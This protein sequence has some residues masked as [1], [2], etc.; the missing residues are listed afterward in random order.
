MVAP[1]NDNFADA[2]VVTL[3]NDQFVSTLTDTTDATLE[4]FEDGSDPAFD[5]SG[6]NSTWWRYDPASDQYLTLTPKTATGG[7]VYYD[8][9]LGPESAN[10]TRLT[11]NQLAD[12]GFT[13]IAL[14]QGQT[15]WVRVTVSLMAPSVTFDF[16]L[17]VTYPDLLGDTLAE[18]IDLL[19]VEGSMDLSLAGTSLEVSATNL[20]TNGDFE[21]DTST[22][23]VRTATLARSTVWANTG[24]AS[25]G[26]TPNS[27]SSTD[28]HAYRGASSSLISGLVPGKTYRASGVSHLEGAITDRTA[29]WRR[30]RIYCYAWT[31]GAIGLGGSDVAPPT[32]GDAK[33]EVIFT[34]PSNATGFELRTY[35]GGLSGDGTLYWDSIALNEVTELVPPGS[36]RSIWGAWAP[37]S[38]DMTA[39]RFRIAQ[40]SARLRLYEWDPVAGALGPLVVESLEGDLIA[41]DIQGTV[42]EQKEYRLQISQPTGA[43]DD[44][45]LEW[46]D[47]S[48]VENNA[49][50]EALETDGVYGTA[51]V[52][53]RNNDM[54]S[55]E[56]S[57]ITTSEPVATSW[58]TF[59]APADKILNW[60]VSAS[61]EMPY[62]IGLYSGVD[63]ATLTQLDVVESF[64]GEDVGFFMVVAQDTQYYLQV[65]SEYDYLDF[66]ISWAEESEIV[67]PYT[68]PEL[69][70]LEDY[71]DEGF[72][73]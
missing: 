17:S 49:F 57:V 43:A 30:R 35:H 21:V 39:I 25:L 10:L 58:L 40:G 19:G 48:P 47:G 34:L 24:A 7:S 15:Y 4:T 73:G 22:W 51:I 6:F 8:L 14:Q 64:A 36:I 26:I 60:L 71:W 38:A 32:A 72:N 44:V 3:V 68:D 12:T 52:S 9:Y 28:S 50:A 41:E 1:V 62:S 53:I 27:G 65:A 20:I 42:D 5:G 23:S 18:P 63:L 29:E 37:P 70:E 69:E 11:P 54:E 46:F 45:T 56:P 31:P 61:P 67:P 16:N 66:D 33:H 59:T 13:D 55:S 2:T